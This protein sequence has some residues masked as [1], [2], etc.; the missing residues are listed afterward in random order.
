MFHASVA[1]APT[2]TAGE[3]VSHVLMQQ[4]DADSAL[5]VTWVEVPPGAAQAP[6]DHAPEQVYV[7]VRGT[8]RMRVGDDERDVAA[9]DLVLAPG[10]VT[11]GITNTGDGPLEYVSAA[12]PAFRVTDVYDRGGGVG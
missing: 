6:H 5:T 4:G 12:T 8:G 10:G 11:H 3:L 2:R 9:G 1:T 7:V